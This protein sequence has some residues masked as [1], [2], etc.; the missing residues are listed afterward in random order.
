MSA[1]LPFLVL[2]VAGI[3]TWIVVAIALWSSS[4]ALRPVLPH[5]WEAP[6]MAEVTEIDPKPGDLVPFVGGCPRYPGDQVDTVWG[7]AIMVEHLGR[8]YY[9]ILPRVR[10][11]RA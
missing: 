8:L 3:F 4:K 7:P 11:A 2:G 5:I 9:Q 6:S 1:N 10:H